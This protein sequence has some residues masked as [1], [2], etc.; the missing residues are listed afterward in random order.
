M[1]V[2][3]LLYL[4]MACRKNLSCSKC[5]PATRRPENWYCESEHLDSGKRMKFRTCLKFLG[6]NLKSSSTCTL[7]FTIRIFTFSFLYHAWCPPFTTILQYRKSAKRLGLFCVSTYSLPV[8][9]VDASLANHVI[10]PR[11]SSGRPIRP[12]G[13]KL[14]H[15]SRR[16][17]CSSIYAAVILV[18]YFISSTGLNHHKGKLT[19]YRYVLEKACSRGCFWVRAH[20]PC[21]EPFAERQTCY[22]CKKPRHDP[23]RREREHSSD[24]LSIL[25]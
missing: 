16:C 1:Q 12:I 10:T 17:G 14:D 6:V 5:S 23:I 11:N 9:N 22:C 24:C 15:F 7:Q 13:F 19:S 25:L 21:F 2:P 8:Q 3:D 18:N 4:I 20:K